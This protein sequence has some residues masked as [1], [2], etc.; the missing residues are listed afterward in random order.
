VAVLAP[1]HISNLDEF[2]PLARVPG[3]RLRWARDVAAMEGA[4][5]IVLPGSKQTSGDLA[6]LHATGLAQAVQ[7]HARAG[8][9]VLG[10]CGGLQILGHSLHD[11]AGSDGE[12][13]GSLPGLGLLPLATHF[14]PHKRLRA[15]RVHF[16]ATHGAWSSLQGVEAAA[17]E[18][19]CGHTLADGPHA[20]LHDA[21]GS[22]IGW[23]AGS[24]LGVYAHGIFE[25]PEVIRALFG[26]EVPTLDT[27]FEGLA[28]LVDTHLEPAL[29]QRLLQGD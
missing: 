6:W 16:T 19:R 15:G 21:A 25:S 18:I 13:Y 3:L 2:T 11:P 23:Q 12:A 29:L 5:W 20:V 7:R 26:A 22:P 27:A 8:R 17:Y 14:G 4:D 9:P 28:D 1:P 10:V 24:V